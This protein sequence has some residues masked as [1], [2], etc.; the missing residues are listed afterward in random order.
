MLLYNDM[1]TEA[2]SSSQSIHIQQVAEVKGSRTPIRKKMHPGQGS[3]YFFNVF[4]E[5]STFIVDE[6]ELLVMIKI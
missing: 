1:D 6:A 4:N 3:Y 5:F 2:T